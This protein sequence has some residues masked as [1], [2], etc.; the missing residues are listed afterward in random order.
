MSM[1][2]SRRATQGGAAGGSVDVVPSVPIAEIRVRKWTK[3]MKTVGHLSIPKWVPGTVTILC[4]SDWP[5]IC[6]VGY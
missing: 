4:T 6:S 5:L 2:L 3:Q 1:R